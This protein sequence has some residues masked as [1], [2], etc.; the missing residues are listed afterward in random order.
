MCKAA[1]DHDTRADCVAWRQV[2]SAMEESEMGGSM[3]VW[4]GKLTF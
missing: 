2:T 1:S 3:E 4:G